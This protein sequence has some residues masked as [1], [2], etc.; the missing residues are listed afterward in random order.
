MQYTNNLLKKWVRRYLKVKQVLSFDIETTGFNPR[1]CKIFSYCLCDA[2]GKVEIYRLDLKDP[3]QTK[4]GWDRLREVCA[5]P[6]IAMLAH[7]Y[8]F[9]LSF[10]K[11]HNVYLHPNKVWHDTMLMSRMLRNLA[12]SHKLHIL[13][14]EVLGYEIETP[15]GLLNSKEIDEKVKLQAGARGDR[16]DKVDKDLMYWY[17]YADAERPMLLY[18]IWEKYFTSNI[19]LLKEYIVEILVTETSERMENNGMRIHYGNI[20][21]IQKFLTGELEEVRDLIFNK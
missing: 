6:D 10:L 20:E 12:Q 13:G 11:S 16:Y 1:K 5:D 19:K 17:Q 8:K 2:H 14:W 3:L 15:F 21:K 18:L 9:E 4:K 7:N